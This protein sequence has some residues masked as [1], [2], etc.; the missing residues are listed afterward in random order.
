MIKCITFKGN[1]DVRGR[2][3]SSKC[4]W[5]GEGSF[6]T[7]SGVYMW[8]FS[9]DSVAASGVSGIGIGVCASGTDMN[10]QLGSCTKSWCFSSNGYK[11]H[12][13]ANTPY[14]KRLG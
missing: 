12:N 5:S 9:I 7:N 14:G 1:L 11:L 3:A 6:Q 8:E 13:N 2:D 10:T 4:I